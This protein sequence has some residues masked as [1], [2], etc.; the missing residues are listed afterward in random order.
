MEPA[1]SAGRR[2]SRAAGLRAALGA[3]SALLL[4]VR[5]APQVREPERARPGRR[6]RRFLP[7]GCGTVRAGGPG[8][9]PSGGRQPR[10]LSQRAAAAAAAAARGPP[11]F[12]S[13][14]PAPRVSPPSP[15]ARRSPPRA[16][17]ALGPR[18]PCSPAPSLA[19]LPPPPPPARGPEGTLPA[20]P[21]RAHAPPEPIT[22]RAGRR[23]AGLAE[24]HAHAHP[25]PPPGRWGRSRRGP[26]LPAP[27]GGSAEE[28]PCG[29][30]LP[31]GP[32]LLSRFLSALGRGRAGHFGALKSFSA[33]NTHNPQSVPFPCGL[34]TKSL[35]PPSLIKGENGCY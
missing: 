20:S 16:E 4:R 35:E 10:R 2:R 11:G 22:G 5:P 9:A 14:S 7:E 3:G 6:R 28:C 17:P 21:G 33:R 25:T 29:P 18:E 32:T 15:I 31:S 19:P 34:F 26:G 27:P 8:S 24:L 30:G 1:P 23:A 12:P 13:P